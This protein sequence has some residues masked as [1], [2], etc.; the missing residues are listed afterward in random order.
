M[1]LLLPFALGAE[2]LMLLTDVE[3]VYDRPPSDPGAKMLTLYRQ[4]SS[5][6]EIGEKSTQG[7]KLE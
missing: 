4:D 7:K 5:E 2:V 3:G 1:T 6:V